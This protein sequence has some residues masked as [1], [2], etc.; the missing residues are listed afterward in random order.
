MIDIFRQVFAV[1]VKSLSSL[2]YFFYFFNISVSLLSPW[3]ACRQGPMLFSFEEAIQLAYER[4]VVLLRYSFV[5]EI[6]PSTSLTGNSPYIG[7]NK[8]NQSIKFEILIQ[9]WSQLKN[10][11]INMEQEKK[12]TCFEYKKRIIIQG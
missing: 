11:L 12:A 2:F 4:S 8:K 10:R 6:M 5:P 3:V 9:F 1:A 7:V